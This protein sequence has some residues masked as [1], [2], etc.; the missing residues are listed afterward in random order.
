MNQFTSSDL[1]KILQASRSYS[2]GLDNIFHRLESRALA[3]HETKIPI[4]HNNLIKESELN[5]RSK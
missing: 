2:V 4:L 5:G 3:D 1:D